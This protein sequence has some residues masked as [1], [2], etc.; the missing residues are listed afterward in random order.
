MTV[1]AKQRLQRRYGLDE[2]SMDIANISDEM[3]LELEAE[4]TA[5]REK[6]IELD[7]KR[8]AFRS[9]WDIVSSLTMTVVMMVMLMS[10]LTSPSSSASCSFYIYIYIPH[11]PSPSP[12][13]HYALQLY[14][15]LYRPQSYGSA[16]G[17]AT[18]PETSDGES[19]ITF[20]SMIQ[21]HLDSPMVM[22]MSIL[23]SPSSSASCSFYIYI[24]HILTTPP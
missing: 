12:S 24:L 3:R 22:V 11:L 6:Y 5:K 19:A 9:M 17:N 8:I 21:Q 13:F 15:P 2:A 20:L 18:V 16:C 4:Y 7:K 1:E 14:V 23:T 10:I